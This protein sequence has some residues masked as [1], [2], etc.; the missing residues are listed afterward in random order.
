M[1]NVK[2]LKLC[3][4][5]LP[6]YPRIKSFR[7]RFCQF[8]VHN[9]FKLHVTLGIQQS[10]CEHLPCHK[11]NVGQIILMKNEPLTI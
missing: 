11:M 4:H 2:F 10:K 8:T 5:F 7:I 9:S 6:S 3:A 1:K